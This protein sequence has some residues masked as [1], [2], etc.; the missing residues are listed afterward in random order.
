MV[1]AGAGARI[2]AWIRTRVRAWIMT[3]MRAKV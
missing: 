2:R 1:S 3:W